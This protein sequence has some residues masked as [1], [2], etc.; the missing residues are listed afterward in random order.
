MLGDDRT[1]SIRLGEIRPCYESLGQM[2][3][4]YARLSH[5]KQVS[6]ILAL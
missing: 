3:P 6:T 2:R 1:E 4:G 5:V